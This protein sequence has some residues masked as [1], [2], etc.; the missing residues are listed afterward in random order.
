MEPSAGG[1][2]LW[3]LAAEGGKFTVNKETALLLHEPAP[4]GAV[5]KD[6]QELFRRKL[7][8]AWLPLDKVFL[9][10]IQLP[11]S[12]PAE[13]QSMVELQLEKLSPLPV[14]HIVWSTFLVPKP[15]AQPDALQTVVVIIALRSY[16]EEFLGELEGMGFLA[17]RLECPVLEELLAININQDG[18]WVFAGKEGEP[19]LVAWQQ[20]GVLQ[21]LT[22]ITLPEGPER[23]Q[24]LKG[25]IEHIAWSAELEGW[26]TAPPTIH[27]VALPAQAAFWEPVLRDL[28]ETPVDVRPP[29]APA[30]LAAFG[31]ER[32]A[33]DGSNSSL[34]PKEFST[35][36]H[37]QFVDG[38]WMRAIF[39]VV[40]IYLAGVLMYFG[41]LYSLKL[42]LQKEQR[43]LAAV[44]PAYVESQKDKQEIDILQKRADLQY[45]AL[46]A[47]KAIAESMPEGVT[48]ND[49][50]FKGGKLEL[51]GTA[52][53][54]DL[55]AI[56][57]FNESLR[58][59]KNVRGEVLFK[60]VGTPKTVTRG[61][62][63]EW[64]FSSATR[65]A[66]GQ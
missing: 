66:E 13:V 46:D 25:Q 38:L 40:G 9:R 61:N 21:N 48:L 31:A 65:E 29:A 30:R 50:Y 12:D 16:V 54:D 59:A 8:V 63:T 39:L 24:Q 55:Q 28:S 14:T 49:M 5:G 23:A 62:Q 58:T 26:L 19:A 15:A 47:W 17:D 45:A 11:T 22:L 34:L 2:R 42:A 57:D 51:H 3:E 32:C 52:P 43:N 7:N 37:Q 36:Y 4:S 33:A 44:T 20:A 1:K 56:Y 6:W 53:V 27:L 35:R 64:T 60:D 10:A 41:A 18:V